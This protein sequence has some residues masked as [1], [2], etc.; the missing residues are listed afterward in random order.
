MAAGGSSLR[1]SHF[2]CRAEIYVCF[3]EQVGYPRGRHR[4]SAIYD[5][6]ADDSNLIPQFFLLAALFLT[7]L[8]MC[9][10]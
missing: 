9:P 6:V 2:S 8:Q 1:I 3:N 4:N 5:V 10:F 7:I